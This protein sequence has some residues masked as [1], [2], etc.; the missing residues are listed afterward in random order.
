MFKQTAFKSC[1]SNGIRV[2]REK[3]T[4]HFSSMSLTTWL[5]L[6]MDLAM[7][8]M[9][10][11]SV[12]TISL[13]SIDDIM[14]QLVRVNSTVKH[15]HLMIF[16]LHLVSAQSNGRLNTECVL[17]D[18]HTTPS[19]SVFSNG[20]TTPFKLRQC[21]KLKR[22]LKTHLFGTAALCDTAVKSAV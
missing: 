17:F 7:P 21:D 4:R 6:S 2:T 13:Q 9:S 15:L 8:R 10:L 12:C 1:N 20:W 19:A 3:H 18:G 16:N 14:T 22:L 11:N 5:K